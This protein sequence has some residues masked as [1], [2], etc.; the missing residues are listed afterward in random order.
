MRYVR[1]VEDHY[2]SLVEILYYCC[3]LCFVEEPEAEL[4]ALPGGR[5]PAAD[6]QLD[7]VEFCRVCEEPIGRADLVAAYE[8]ATDNRSRPPRPVDVDP[9]PLRQRHP[10]PARD[11]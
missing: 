4:A 2:G 11:R 6:S 7:R 3:R 9:S 8:A 5:S 1:H 10:R